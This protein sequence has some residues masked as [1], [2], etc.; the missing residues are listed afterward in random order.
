MY[1][2]SVGQNTPLSPYRFKVLGFPRV[3]LALFF[4]FFS[5]QALLCLWS[6]LS[7]EEIKKKKLYITV[8]IIIHLLTSTS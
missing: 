5:L 7:C 3:N 4:F 2:V 1:E 8:L 6:E